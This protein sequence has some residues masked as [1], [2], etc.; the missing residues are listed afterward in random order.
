MASH[1]FTAAA[2]AALAISFPVAL[3]SVAC[4]SNTTATATA[5]VAAEPVPTVHV[6]SPAVFDGTT[7]KGWRPVGAA[8]WKAEGG[9]IV[10]TVTNGPGWLVLDTVYGDTGVELAFECDNCEPGVMIRSEQQ[11][12]RTNGV[13]LELAGPTAG[14]LFRV[15]F[16]AQGKEI[17]RKPMPKYTAQVISEGPTYLITGGCPPVPCAGIRDAHGG[18]AG[19]PGS[20]VQQGAFGLRKGTANTV[21]FSA[22]GDVLTGNMNG[23]RLPNT[24]MDAG[25]KFGKVA[26]RVGGPSGAALRVTKIGVRDYTTRVAGLA[27]ETTDSRFRK[28]QLNDIFY[29]EGVGAGDLNRDGRQDVVAGPFYYLGPDFQEAREFYPPATINI[30]G[31]EYPVDRR[32]RRWARLHTATIRR[33]SCRGCTT[34]TTTA[35]TTSSR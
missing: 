7:L 28:V 34:S 23:T 25:K 1:M 16:D 26:L 22:G 6:K 4:S 24:V 14:S 33:R 15:T 35:G 19:S 31:A 30:A 21:L 13:Y 32:C 12:D 9:A 8:Q 18:G 10:G 17:D 29:A 3:L 11:G 5:P 27:P 2:R 20:I